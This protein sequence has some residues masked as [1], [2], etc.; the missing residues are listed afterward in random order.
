MNQTRKNSEKIGFIALNPQLVSLSEI[1]QILAP[2]P[3]ELYK[4]L[5]NKLDLDKNGSLSMNEFRLIETNKK[6]NYQ[7]DLKHQIKNS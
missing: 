3:T 7:N 1:K 2:S 6:N 4:K 5:F